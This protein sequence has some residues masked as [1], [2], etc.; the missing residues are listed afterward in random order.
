M[1]VCCVLGVFIARG[2]EDA[3][4]TRSIVPGE[5]VYGEKKVSVEVSQCLFV[6]LSVCSMQWNTCSALCRGAVQEVECIQ[7]VHAVIVGIKFVQ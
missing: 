2:K 7:V 3:L 6:C 1:Y 5:A 4:V